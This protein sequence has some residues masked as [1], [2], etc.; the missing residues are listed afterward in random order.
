MA[1]LIVLD[2]G[3][4]GMI[5]RAPSKPHIVRCLTW[6]KTIQATG[7][8]VIIAGGGWAI[9]QQIKKRRPE[10]AEWLHRLF[11]GFFV[12]ANAKTFRRLLEFDYPGR[13]SPLLERV[14][15]NE[16]AECDREEQDMLTDSLKKATIRFQ[17]TCMMY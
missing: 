7:A 13:L 5:I 9:Y 14:L 15:I 12:D 16:E 8:V 6:L 2:S 17:P 11:T 1:R 10:S 3:P 4:L